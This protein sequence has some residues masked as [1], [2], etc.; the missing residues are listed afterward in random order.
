MKR[1]VFIILS[2]F[3]FFLL[4]L[5]VIAQGQQ[6]PADQT[7]VKD[8]ISA[9]TTLSATVLASIEKGAR[10]A[11]KLKIKWSA[12]L[13]GFG[14]LFDFQSAE[15]SI[16]PD[17]YI[18]QL[19][20]WSGGIY[21]RPSFDASYKKISLSLQP[22]LNTEYDH[23]HTEIDAR[24]YF[25]KIL[26]KYQLSNK[27]LIKGGRYF[28]QT[29]TGL[30]INP[31]NAFSH[32]PQRINPK[33]EPRPKDYAELVFSTNNNWTITGIANLFK[34]DDLQYQSP[35]FDF[36]RRYGIQIEK[37]GSSSQIGTLISVDEQGKAALG[38]YGQKNLGEAFVLWTDM[39]LE[40]K[41]DRFYPQAGHPTNLVNYD[42]I[43]GNDNN[44]FFFSGLAGISYT[45][46]GGSTFYAEYYYNGRSYDDQ[47][48]YWNADMIK[49]AS[50]YTIDI[51][52]ELSK[53]NLARA[54]NN[55]N[56][57]DGRH[58]LFTQFVKNDL[59]DKI[60]IAGRYFWGLDN[61]IHQASALIEFNV[62]DN[63][64]IFNTTL[65]NLGKNKTD[66]NKL[67]IYQ[68]MLGLIFHF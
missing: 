14:R 12:D 52:R 44:R 19:N 28:R 53:R 57:Y 63:L 68:T 67:V 31:S 41:I 45:L 55:G 56:Q 35:Y 39:G 37:Y 18:A 65:V 38:L 27:L 20:H 8:S 7:A 32:D 47:Q 58:Y 17:N 24:F 9:D 25:Q 51:T 2:L 3:Q 13:L 48:R 4:S 1:T 21:L 5:P 30:F 36:S 6:E 62:L 10:T 40:H 50:N 43:N 59:F 26:L 64:E 61:N 42:M 33:I 49:T 29:G 23:Y 16:N 60:N 11:E 54:I 34:G 22:R 46:K 66:F 15:G